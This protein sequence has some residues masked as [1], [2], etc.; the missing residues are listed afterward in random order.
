MKYSCIQLTQGSMSNCSNLPQ[1]SLCRFRFRS[2]TVSRMVAAFVFP[3]DIFRHPTKLTFTMTTCSLLCH[4]NHQMIYF[5]AQPKA[6]LPQ[7]MIPVKLAIATSSQKALFLLQFP[8]WYF[9]FWS[10]DQ[11]FCKSLPN[12]M[13]RHLILVTSSSHIYKMKMGTSTK[14]H[15]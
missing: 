9:Y 10:H 2:G 7:T 11:S 13:I 12:H 4:M 8:S 6:I 14:W 5:D 3:N 1:N 15:M